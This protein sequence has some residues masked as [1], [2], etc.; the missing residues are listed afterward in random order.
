MQAI[1]WESGS[2]IGPGIGDVWMFRVRRHRLL[3]GTIALLLSGLGPCVGYA[4]DARLLAQCAAPQ[5]GAPAP[6]PPAGSDD[7]AL[8]SPSGQP[9]TV[10]CNLWATDA[11]A[12][13]GVKA[14]IKGRS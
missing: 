3:P 13:K 8:A 5:L 6:L 1:S 11:V 2:G 9:T 10:S 7:P 4:Q 14:S 12:F